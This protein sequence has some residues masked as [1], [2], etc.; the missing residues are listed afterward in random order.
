MNWG[1]LGCAGIAQKAVIP[2]ILSI[3]ENKLVA[4]S[5]RNQESADNF[6]KKFGC[7]GIEGY[8]ELLKR[9]DLD[10]VYIPLPN[11][12]H[13]EWIMKALEHNKHVLVEKA[14]FI[15]LSEAQEAVDL[16]R[17][18]GLGIVE[19]FQ[20]QHH[21]QNTFVKKML[22][23][24]EIGE[25]RCFR[26]SFGFPPFDPE[27]NIRYKP[28]LGGGALLDSG[29]YVL[30]AS[31]FFFGHDFEVK[32]AHLDYHEEYGVDWFGGAFLIN[33]ANGI[34]AE[35]AFGFD[36]YYQC[37]YE[38]WGS[39]G[40]ITATRAF[41]AKADFAPTIILEKNGVSTEIVLETDDHFRNMLQYFNQ[42]VKEEN[43]EPELQYI[44][45]QARLIEQVRQLGGRN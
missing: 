16:A 9:D 34:F 4:V 17:K 32:A 7:I 30:K 37:N 31:S 18:K 13:F 36:N 42:T 45:T 12:L 15:S 6:A 1:I 29:A 26:S 5:S 27:T 28:E 10:A 43:F 40:K 35:V 14:A 21:S 41:T 2:A 25:I 39:T 38:I 24:N 8:E 23:K 11:G 33:K 44:L 22:V 19:N 20:F 3:N